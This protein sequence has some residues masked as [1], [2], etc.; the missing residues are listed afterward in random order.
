MEVIEEELKE[1]TKKRVLDEPSY[2]LKTNNQFLKK[3]HYF[4]LD[5]KVIQRLGGYN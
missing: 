1:Y 5:T 4:C 2:R 3:T